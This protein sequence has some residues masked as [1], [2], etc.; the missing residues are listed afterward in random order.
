[1]GYAGIFGL[2]ASGVAAASRGL[3]LLAL[4]VSAALGAE[5]SV[6]TAPSGQVFV[7]G[8]ALHVD[9]PLDSAAFITGGY[10][11]DSAG[12]TELPVVGR[13]HVAGKT[14]D[15]LE[16]YLGQKLSNYLKDTHIRA[17]PCIRLTL[18]GHWTRQGQFYVSPG[19]TVWEAVR[20]AGGIGG[21]RN[22][23]K[24]VVLRGDQTLP[25][26]LLEEYS[27][28]RTLRGAGI[29]SGDIFMI[30]V[31]RDNSGFWYWFTQG[32]T[33]TAQIATIAST[34]LTSYITY[35]LITERD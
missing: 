22:L 1:M 6:S 13:L 4:L 21:E 2:C 18:L 28:G 23:D 12:Y 15:D 31:P 24:L 19:A 10:A 7:A 32:L 27:A 29:R 25:I 9:V 17:V 30:P 35:L 33:A 26:R 14:R 8:E 20:M 16:T 5:G 11:I 34:V 3:L